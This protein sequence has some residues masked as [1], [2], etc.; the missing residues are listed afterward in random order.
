MKMCKTFWRMAYLPS[1]GRNRKYSV[2]GV[3]KIRLLLVT[4]FEAHS[5]QLSL[6]LIRYTRNLITDEI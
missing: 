1:L 2:C 4:K 5:H 3:I 6:T